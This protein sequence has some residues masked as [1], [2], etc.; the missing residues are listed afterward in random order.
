[1]GLRTR[2]AAREAW[3]APS[4]AWI[5]SLDEAGFQLATRG[6]A[7]RRTRYRGLVRNALVAA[8]NAGDLAL[9]PAVARFA[10][11]EDE[12]LREHACWALGRMD[13]LG[14]VRTRASD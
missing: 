12:L 8:G 1:M 4:L 3:R 9:R 13:R 7:L 14:V 6:T 5:L 2:L 10:E 11:S